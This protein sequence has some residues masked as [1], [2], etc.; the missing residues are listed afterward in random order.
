M[1]GMTFY[2]QPKQ[3]G[4]C[5]SGLNELD[6][7]TALFWIVMSTLLTDATGPNLLNTSWS[8][9]GTCIDF[10]L[11]LPIKINPAGHWHED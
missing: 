5:K 10:G 4:K 2:I 8:V 7:C 11:T 6:C 1:Q 3:T 9:A